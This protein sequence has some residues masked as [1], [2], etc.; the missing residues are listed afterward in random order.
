M[1]I[2]LVLTVDLICS[3]IPF[4]VTRMA[5]LKKLTL[6]DNNLSRLSNG[7]YLDQL[8]ELDLSHNSFERIPEALQA[9]QKLVK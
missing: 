4:A 5:S 7:P 1:S 9:A 3:E 6:R 2:W 8:E